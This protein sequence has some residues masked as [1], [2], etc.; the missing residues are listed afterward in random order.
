MKG[1]RMDT[2]FF[3]LGC[4]SPFLSFLAVMTVRL[5]LPIESYTLYLYLCY[6]RSPKAPLPALARK[7]ND[8]PPYRCTITHARCSGLLLFLFI[9]VVIITRIVLIVLA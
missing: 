6:V 7:R 1:R 9:V 5:T 8:H 2:F 3:F 4:V